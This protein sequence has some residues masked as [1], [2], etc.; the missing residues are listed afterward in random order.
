MRKVK[1]QKI[2]DE[3]QIRYMDTTVYYK[4]FGNSK[5]YVRLNRKGTHEKRR[6][7]K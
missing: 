2:L 1:L 4:E 5:G 7:K 3:L 6:F